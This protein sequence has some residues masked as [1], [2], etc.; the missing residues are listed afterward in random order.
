MSQLVRLEGKHS[1][2]NAHCALVT[3]VPVEP[4]E[5]GDKVSIY[6]LS[7]DTWEYIEN[8]YDSQILSHVPSEALSLA[9]CQ[10][11][12]LPLF[13]NRDMLKFVSF[14]LIFPHHYSVCI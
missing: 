2:Q 12:S 9:A 3:V 10:K 4:G 8:I 1:S 11:A 14:S 7:Q 13:Q 6:T 5:E